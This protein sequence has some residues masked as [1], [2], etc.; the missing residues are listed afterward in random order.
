VLAEHYPE[1][2]DEDSPNRETKDHFNRAVGL[3]IK[4]T[5]DNE[6]SRHLQFI[7]M[8]PGGDYRLMKDLVTPPRLHAQRFKEM[9]CIA[10]ILPAGNI[11]KPSDALALQW[12][13]MSY[14][15]SDREKFVLGGKT[16]KDATNETVTKIFQ[17][18]YEQQKLDGLLDR[19]EVERLKKRLL[20][21]AL[22]DLRC[23]VHDATDDRCTYRAKRKIVRRDDRR[24]YDV[25]CNRDHRRYIDDDRND[26]GR[27]SS[28]GTSKRCWGLYNCLDGYSRYPR[29]FEYT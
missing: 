27:R 21:K 8:Q 3:F 1:A 20:H 24:R 12:Y 6:K 19:Q 11:L 9:L 15:K 23:K 17:A 10:E 29:T 25:D 7:Y 5:L 16:L 13:Y 22:E 26:N 4:K 18:L 2:L 14:H 28:R